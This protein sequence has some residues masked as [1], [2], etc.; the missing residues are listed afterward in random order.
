MLTIPNPR[1][2]RVMTKQTKKLNYL[3]MVWMNVHNKTICRMIIT[4][5]RM[6]TT[7]IP[8][9][10]LPNQPNPSSTQAMAPPTASGQ[11]APGCQ[12]CGLSATMASNMVD[13]R[14]DLLRLVKMLLFR[15]QQHI[16]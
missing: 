13:Q 11:L 9:T 3:A 7:Q 10:R 6:I 2:V 16:W 4:G 15:C 14:R 1:K 5:M 8:R 12:D